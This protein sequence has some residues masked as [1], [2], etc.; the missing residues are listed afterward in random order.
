MP[1]GIFLFGGFYSHT[2]W[3]W[4]PSGINQW[5]SG[6][7]SIPG[8]FGFYEGCAVKINDA[9]ILLIGGA[10]TYKRVLKFNTNTNQFT[11]L[12]DVLNQGRFGH[13]CTLYENQIIIA[14]GLGSSYNN[15]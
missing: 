2:T 1:G 8:K 15:D 9:E 4:L 10:G 5:Q 7:T 3:E 11:N 6:N 14:G 13:K 12:G